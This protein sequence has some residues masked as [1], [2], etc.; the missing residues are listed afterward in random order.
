MPAESQDELQPILAA[1]GK[2][3]AQQFHDFRSSSSLGKIHQ[4]KPRGN[5]KVAGSMDTEFHYLCVLNSRPGDPGFTEYRQSA[6][7]EEASAGTLRESYMLTSGFASAAL[8]FHPSFQCGSEFQFLGN[9]KLGG[10]ETYVIAFAQIPVKAKL[11]GDFKIGNS[12]A[13]TFVQGLAW[14]DAQNDQILRLRTDL[15]KPLAEVRLAQETTQIDYHDV[16]IKNLSEGF[17]LPRDVR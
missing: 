12:S 6:G 11:V 17:W 4:E 15:L 13:P 16:Y 14:I 3:V 8:I 10:R 7:G 9:Q 5:G 2:K 1:V